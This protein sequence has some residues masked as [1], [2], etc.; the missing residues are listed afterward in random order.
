MQIK[1]IIGA[2]ALSLCT[3]WA[4]PVTD[5]RLSSN[6]LTP[7]GLLAPRFTCD[8]ANIS[9]SLRFS[10]L[11][12]NTK[13]L[14]I[15]MDDPDAP[16]GLFTHWLVWNIEPQTKEFTAGSPPNGV[17]QGKNDFGQAGYGGPCPPSGEHR[18][19]ITLFALDMV[20]TLAAGAKRAQ[21]DAALKGHILGKTVLPARY[22][23]APLSKQ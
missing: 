2:L 21:F 12:E 1:R 8:G 5:L 6:D 20:P 17:M 7:G 11:P 15:V 14:A 13:S 10:G 9:P 19:N 4:E 16:S 3:A 22:S 18:Y 23:R